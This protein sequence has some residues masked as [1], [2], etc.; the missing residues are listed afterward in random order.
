MEAKQILQNVL[1]DYHQITRLRSYVVYNPEDIRGSSEKNYFCKC[2]K[3]SGKALTKCERCISEVFAEATDE[4]KECVYSCHAGLIKWAVP[5][6]HG[7]EHCVIVS[8]GILAQK[9]ME[10]AEQ[11]S[12]YLSHEYNLQE[13]MI[14]R[15]FKVIQTMNEKQMR[16]SIELLK[17]LIEYHFAMEDA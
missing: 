10:E 12:R 2:L 8:E 15:N 17:D 13:D 11:W 5:V 4:S 7:M 3:L 1:N 9:Q 6:Q 16:A 14:L